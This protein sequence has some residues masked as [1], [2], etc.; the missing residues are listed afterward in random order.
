MPHHDAPTRVAI[1]YPGTSDASPSLYA[2]NPVFEGV[3]A[4]PN[5]TPS[6][7]Q[8]PLILFSHGMGGT[9]RA[10]AW[11][12]AALA[13]RGVIT[14]MLNHPNSTWLDF[15]MSAGVQHWT[16]A[17]DM[18]TALDTILE[19]PQFANHID[20]SRITAAGF[21]FGG[22]T[23][24]SMGGLRGNHAGIVQTCTD[25]PDMSACGM[26]LSPEVNLAGL[27]PADWNG[28]YSDARVS[29]VVAIDPGL[30]WGLTPSDVAELLPETLM[31]GLG[32][33]ERLLAADFDQ[34]GLADLLDPQ[35]AWRIAPA[36]HFSVMPLCTAMGPTIL[37]AEGDDPVCTDPDGADRADIHAQVIDLMVSALGL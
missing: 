1:W 24:L 29:R 18:S 14:V 15:D 7:G 35:Q 25:R 37:E 34:S 13:E 31:I 10:Q 33:E 2:S 3:E 20:Q 19:M 16:R 9:D 27:D 11:L 6:N 8:F 36:Y 23:A 30:I 12:A 17:Q 4:Y 26:M 32:D 22:W 5:A 28:D 21:S